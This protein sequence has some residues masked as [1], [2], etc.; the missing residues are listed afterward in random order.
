M[1][2]TASTR[3]TDSLVGAGPFKLVRYE[4]GSRG[5]F[6]RNPHWFRKDAAGNALP[7]LDTVLVT[8]VQDQ[9][10]EVLKFKAGEL[11]QM[12]V[13]PQ[14]FPVLK[15]LEAEGAFTIRKLGPTLNSSFRLLQPE[16]GQGQVGEAIP[17][18]RQA[19]VVLRRPFSSRHELGDRPQ[20][21][22]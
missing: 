1:L 12:D 14:D 20:G 17:R 10:A 18:S 4:A 21:H 15:P 13:T 19:L 9:K 8:I 7:Y 2:P 11:D 6:V 5:V 16:S 3:P 22:P